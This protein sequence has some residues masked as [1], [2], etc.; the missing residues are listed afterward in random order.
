[1]P[2]GR[3]YHLGMGQ[4]A[5]WGW[6]LAGI[7]AAGGAAPAQTLT[8]Q[9]LNGKYFFRHV[10]LGTVASG[11]LADPRSLIGT[12][13][14]DGQGGYTYTAQQVVGTGA[15]APQSGSGKY[16][17]DAAGFVALD[18]PLRTGARINARV[19][20]EALLGSDTESGGNTFD[21]LVAIPAPA[22]NA[23]ATL[24]GPYW[25][26]SLEFPGAS[27]ANARNTIFSLSSTAPG[28]FANFSVQ[29]HAANLAGG[30]PIAQPVSG[31]T[32][33][34]GADGV[35]SASFGASATLL[36][37]DKTVYVSADGNII[38]G[39]A[40]AGGSHD[41]VIG[42]KAAAGVTAAT[43]NG[44]YWSAG[45][46]IDPNAVTGYA[47]SAAARGVGRV[48]WSRRLKALGFG[49]SDFTATDGYTLNGDGSGTE[50][51]SMVGLGAGGKMFVGSA[52][53][54]DDAGA[55]EIFFGASMATLSGSG[56]FLDPQGV[57][58]GASSAPAGNPISPGEFIS[59]YG[60]G[61][62]KGNATATAP[63][64][65]TLNGVTVLVN[66]KAAPLFAV[67]AGQVNALV[68]Y[69]TQGPTATIVVQNGTV[70]S[71]TVTIA[72][73]PISPG[74]FSLDQS[75]TGAG[76][77]VHGP[78]N[79]GAVTA[80]SPATAGEFVSIFL[81]GMGAVNPAVTDGTAGGA[82]PASATTLPASGNCAAG[83]FCV[84]V[85]GQPARVIFSGLAPG[86]PGLYQINIQIPPLFGASGALPL[87]IAAPTAF[88]DQVSIAIQ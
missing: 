54:G 78:P 66:G 64:P 46:R 11:A 80:A 77:V 56:V 70:S 61:L 47:G 34:M 40:T 13:T 23:G 58:N 69:S 35:G 31:A 81:T 86:F 83:S 42:V 28:Q 26:V 36:S 3:V 45:L 18:S 33:T 79:F 41:M 30:A 51:L 57:V 17:V 76:A 85:A 7:L 49:A 15:A 72:V 65:P 71:N 60:S 62:A 82:N 87:A 52:I 74:I 55:F 27:A 14:F 2:R 24:A 12:M 32:Y 25:T 16:A 38:L 73:A 50:E 29:G 20:P 22:S 88:H 67:S 53:S 44:N 10:S 8:D 6:L 5:G 37:G 63:F 1:M 19:G 75:G 4:R 84:L 48:T 43:W 21:L 59:L 68:P 9:A 39:G